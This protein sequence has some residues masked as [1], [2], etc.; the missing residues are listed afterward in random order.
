MNHSFGR[1]YQ[2]RSSM[3]PTSRIGATADNQLNTDTRVEGVSHLVPR[4]C[5]NKE[6]ITTITASKSW[7]TKTNF[8]QNGTK[9][10]P[11]QKALSFKEIM[12]SASLNCHAMK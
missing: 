9:S 1:S 2:T 8:V 6:G 4:N 11:A 5:T 7:G 10:Q 12:E 3:T